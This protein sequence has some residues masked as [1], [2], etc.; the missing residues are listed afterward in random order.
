MS[1]TLNINVL[2]AA[3]EEYTKQLVY[4]LSPEI[5]IVLKNIF[6]ESQQMKKKRNISLR[7]YQILLKRIPVWNTI[8]IEKHTK[9][10]KSKIPY[11]LDLITAIFVSH[12][13]I[14][15]C[16]R[17]KADSKSIQVKVP[18]LDIFLHKIIITNAE[19]IYYNPEIILKKKEI[20]I[21]VISDTIEETIRNQIPIDKILTEYLAGVFDED[22]YE[23][24]NDNF[25]EINNNEEE[26][27]ELEQESDSDESD[28]NLDNK[29]IVPTRPLPSIQQPDNVESLE[30]LENPENKI[31]TTEINVPQDVPQN[32]QQRVLFSDAVEKS[33]KKKDKLNSNEEDY[34]S[35]TDSENEYEDS[36]DD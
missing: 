1:E 30:S 19:K 29:N 3:K 12:V 9:D 23:N 2:V 14:L 33:I 15:A 18:N 7:N 8:L 16:V 25:P 28:N 21:E 4:I 34:E 36:D 6:N 27:E 5:Y 26:I 32:N 17:L 20:V 10:M 35:D 22:S 24:S 31:P 11:L 13:K